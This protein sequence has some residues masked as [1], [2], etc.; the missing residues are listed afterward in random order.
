[1]GVVAMKVLAASILGRMAKFTVPDYDP[2]ARAKLPGAA[3]RWVLNDPRV[4]LL[5]LGMGHAEEI[6]QNAAMLAADLTLTDADRAL[7]SDYSERVYKSERIRK[8]RIV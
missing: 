5:N 7:L 1:M 4:S 6:D 2:A 3:I 8:M